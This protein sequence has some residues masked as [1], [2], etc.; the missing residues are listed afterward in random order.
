MANQYEQYTEVPTNEG[1]GFDWKTVGIIIGAVIIAVIIIIAAVVF[2]RNLRS[3]ADTRALETEA[4]DAAESR[5]ARELAECEVAEDPEACRVRIISTEATSISAAE[6]CE[7]LEESQLAGCVELVAR[8]RLDPDECQAI[9][10]GTARIECEDNVN[11]Q[12]ILDSGQYDDCSDLKLSDNVASCEEQMISQVY[13]SGDC[14]KY[15]ID[16]AY[17]EAPAQ[18]QAA[19]DARNPDLCPVIDGEY[20]EACPEKVGDKDIDLDD[21]SADYEVEHGLNDLNP[22]IDADGLND[23]EELS[24]GTDPFDTDSD[25]DGLIDGVEVNVYGSDPLDP[26]SDGDGYPDGSE[27][28]AGYSPTGSGA[29]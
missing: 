1:K 20:F 24:M 26:D 18:V 11:L 29:L 16:Q 6:L 4:I 5:I 21:L 13:T 15:G 17:C 25:N 10:D 8:D 2:V 7:M 23:G 22:D 27:V 19:I 3:G 28:E 14:A 12:I 9:D